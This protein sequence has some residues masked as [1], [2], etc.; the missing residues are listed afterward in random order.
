[1]DLYQTVEPSLLKLK[2]RITKEGILD[3]SDMDYEKYLRTVFWKEVKEWILER[4]N[5]RCVVCGAEKSRFCDLEVHHRSYELDVLE[6]R[7]S[8]MLISLCPRCHKLIEFYPDGCKRVYLNEK[9]EKYFE[10]KRLHSEIES[11]G[12]A[13]QINRY[14]RKGGELFEIIYA[15]DSDYLA[16]YSVESLMFG[17]VLNVRQRHHDELKIPLPFGRGKLYQKSGAKISNKVSGKEV[18]NVK[19]TEG[20]PVIK[21][22]KFCRYPL[23]EYLAAYISEKKYWYV[24]Q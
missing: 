10:L 2:R 16:F 17:F 7:N 4:D 1:M 6:G 11:N 20:N 13:L 23:H 14:S 18:I 5:H 24:V 9:D 8:E 3:I 21:A 15:G 12:L 19:I 22:S